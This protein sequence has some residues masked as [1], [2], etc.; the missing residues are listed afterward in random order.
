M[1]TNVGNGQT[2]SGPS[3]QNDPDDAFKSIVVQ[4][5]IKLEKCDPD[6]EKHD[7][8]NSKS[9]NEILNEI[10]CALNVE[11]PQD[12]FEKIDENLDA[13]VHSP[14]QS[15]DRSRSDSSTKKKHKKSKSMFLK[16]FC[17]LFKK[18]Q[19]TILKSLKQLKIFAKIVNKDVW[20]KI[21]TFFWYPFLF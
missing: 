3:D 11:V 8:T 14:V 20:G 16:I 21:S 5:E 4:P 18:R 7:Q 12:F 17:V 6:Y 9:S 15:A 1:T 19:L 10:F 2:G 13:A